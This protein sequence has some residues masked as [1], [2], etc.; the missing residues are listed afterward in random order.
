MPVTNFSV[1]STVEFTSAWDT[2]GGI[3][4]D[5]TIEF[6]S[7]VNVVAEAAP[8]TPPSSVVNVRR[9]SETMP[10]PVLTDG[11]PDPKVW[12]PT[13]RVSEEWGRLQL[14]V[15]GQD[16]TYFRGI[17]AQIGEWGSAEPFDDDTAAIGFPQITDFEGMP[18]WLEDHCNVEIRLVRPDNSIKPLWEGLY[19]SDEPNGIQAVG[20]LYQ[21]DFSVKTPTLNDQMRDPTFGYLHKGDRDIGRLIAQEI[22]SRPYLRLLPPQ[23]PPGDPYITGIDSSER[24]SFDQ[25]LTGYIQTLLSTAFSSPILSDG[26]KAVGIET[27]LDGVGYWIVGSLGSV[28]PFGVRT[29]Y[30]GSMLGIRLNEQATGI[31]ALD[32]GEAYWYAAEDGGVFTFGTNFYGSETGNPN[33]IVEIETTP[34]GGGYWL[35]DTIGGVFAFGNAGYFGSLP[36]SSITPAEPVVDFVPTETGL[37]YWILSRDGG[38]YAYGDAVYHGNST[39]VPDREWVAIERSKDG[40]GY[41]LLNT[42]GEIDSFGDAV[43][44]GNTPDPINEPA[45][46]MARTASGDGYWIVAEDGGVFSL[47]DAV[48]RGN[49]FDGRGEVHQWTLS[50]N[51]GRIPVLKVKDTR[52]V[53][54]TV[55]NGA[56]GVEAHLSRDLSMSPNVIF[57][58]GIN[59]DRCKW[60][61]TKYPVSTSGEAPVWSG[62]V[63]DIGSTH[64]DVLLWQREMLAHGWGVSDTGTYTQTDA[65]VCKRFQA[66]AGL[67][68]TGKVN[69]QTWAATFDVGANAGALDNAYIAPLNYDKRIEPYTYSA[70]GAATGSNPDYDPSIMR[71]ERFENYG[72]GMERDKAIMLA[73]A[74]ITHDGI[75][76]YAGTIDLKIDP[77]EG[78]RFEIKAGQNIVLR[79]HR[80]VDRFLHIASVRQNFSSLSV[81]LTVDELGRDRTTLAAILER[82]RKP[83]DPARRRQYRNTTSKQTV[84]SRAVWDCESGAGII[85][86][87]AIQAGIWNVLRI[88]C[89]EMGDV[90]RSEFTTAVPAQMAVGIFD[91]PVTP[92]DLAGMPPSTAN[93]WDSFDEDSGLIIAW[94]GENQMGGYYPN[95]QSDQPTPALTGKLLDNASWYFESTQ[96][97]YLW[98]ALW[99]ASPGLNHISGKLAPAA[100]GS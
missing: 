24:G 71:V 77:Q 27:S 59:R 20:A 53:H 69:A 42:R 34:D 97:P 7:S 95:L 81:A 10:N 94:G 32:S 11:K 3:E 22:T 61:N 91:R 38:V 65:G 83:D 73:G 31:A 98:V 75:A 28:I 58:E 80:G 4:V 76:Q 57:G 21:L 23:A 90:V 79:Q 68:V 17:P 1:D 29:A 2:G 41:W 92:A 12:V 67:S 64:P 39:A 74:E 45:I 16:V 55:M 70:N 87:H 33:N 15:N 18:S 47:G 19:A 35:V 99:V 96:P 56:R 13:S 100:E 52:H 66:Q 84:D 63:L 62:T 6:F 86:Y 48:Y 46:D 43:Y 51:P 72:E 14:L 25:L 78:S 93:Y 44:H 50:K 8:V 9:L 30:H 40:D 49:G 82:D 5:A 89:G 88:P 36:G 37:G 26:E 85:P 60:R 54:W